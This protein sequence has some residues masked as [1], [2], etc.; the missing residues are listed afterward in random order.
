MGS[1]LR[2]RWRAICGWIRLTLCGALGVG[3][4]WRGRL[5]GGRHDQL[6]C[7]PGL[8]MRF[9]R[10]WAEDLVRAGLE[11]HRERLSLARWNILRSLVD[12]IT[13]YMK[14]VGHLA[15]VVD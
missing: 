5:V 9:L 2:R 7:H 14:A 10:H 15:G 12:A 8:F 6:S 11:R 1:I 13:L 4:R 3:F